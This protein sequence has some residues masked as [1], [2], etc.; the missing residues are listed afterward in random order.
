M[1]ETLSKK[2]VE[3]LMNIPYATKDDKEKIEIFFRKANEKLQKQ[4]KKGTFGKNLKDFKENFDTLLNPTLS[5]NRVSFDSF[6]K[7]M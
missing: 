5:F 1:Y 2:S 7:T 4:L 3:S 6:L